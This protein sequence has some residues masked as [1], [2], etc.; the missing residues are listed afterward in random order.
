MPK[1][2]FN[3][4][5]SEN[6]EKGTRTLSLVM[7]RNCNLSCSYCY[8]KHKKQDSVMMDIEL[9][10]KEISYFMELDILQIV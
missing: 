3:K 4:A 1:I 8:E 5:F 9:A 6:A 7:T 2:P 10:K